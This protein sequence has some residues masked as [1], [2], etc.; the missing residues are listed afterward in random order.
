VWTPSH[1]STRGSIQAGNQDLIGSKCDC[2]IPANPPREVIEA[3]RHANW[4]AHGDHDE[5]H[6]VANQ[7][8][9]EKPGDRGVDCVKPTGYRP[10][11]ETQK[12]GRRLAMRIAVGAVQVLC[13]LGTVWKGV[14]LMRARAVRTSACVV[15]VLWCGV[16]FAQDKPDEKIAAAVVK[17]YENPGT[18][19]GSLQGARRPRIRTA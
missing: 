3:R 6:T 13:Q 16:S 9:G 19:L 11:R 8:K 18:A 1:S 10:G 7:A 12:R 4:A 17:N 2:L 14:L 5:Y 15:V